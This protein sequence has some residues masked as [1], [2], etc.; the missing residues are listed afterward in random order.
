[1]IEE[2]LL[3]TLQVSKDN[4]RTPKFM[5]A[6]LSGIAEIL[7]ETQTLLTLEMVLSEK[8]LSFILVV[9]KKVSDL[10]CGQLASQ[11]P[12]LETEAVQDYVRIPENTS[13]AG[14][15]LPLTKTDILPIQTY[16]HFE[17]DTLSH[18]SG[19]F[20]GFAANEKAWIQLVLG[21]VNKKAIP[22]KIS[23]FFKSAIRHRIRSGDAD[24][25]SM[26]I[27]EEEN[28]AVKALFRSTIRLVCISPDPSRA[29]LELNA[30]VSTFKL[31]TKPNLNGFKEG[32]IRTDQEFLLYYK[33][34]LSGKK[35]FL[36]NS[37]E[38]ASIF[39]FPYKGAEIPQVIT[40]KAKRAEPP[41][42][43]PREGSVDE[44]D[45]SFFGETTFRNEKIRFGVKSVDRNR[46]FYTIGK[47]GMGKSKLLE[48]MILE[49]LNHGKGV[50][51]LDPH[52][53]LC[54][55]TLKYIPQ[56]RIYDTIYFN[57]AD[58]DYP[59]GFNPMEKVE[60][61]EYKQNVV[62]GF[63][64]IFKKLFGWNW[65][66][67]LEHVLRYTVL[68]LLDYPNSTVL[69]IPRMLSDNLFRQEVISQIHDP[70]VKKFWTTEFASWSDQFSQEA[71]VPIINKVG[72]FVA[73]PLI[74]N[75]VGQPQSV[76]NLSEIMNNG[77]I[78]LCNLSAGKLGEEN[79]ALLGSMFVTKIWQ[80]ALERAST[81]EQERKDFYLY[82]DE[83]Q[84][85][86]TSAFANI[87]SEARKYRLCLIF[88]HQY[89]GQLPEGISSTIF[90]NVGSIVS[91]RVG[92]EDAAILEK[93]FAPEFSAKDLMNLDMREIYVK[94]AIDG[95][96]ALPFSAKTITLPHVDEDYSQDVIDFSRRKWAKPRIEVEK[97]IM[98][99]ESKEFKGKSNKI[100]SGATEEEQKF[101]EPIV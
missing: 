90:G 100:A 88:A 34:R 79:A 84:N 46:H 85:F 54:E 8:F 9:P 4:E 61:F 52:G 77:K 81:P 7:R 1:M 95:Q 28:K 101:S 58:I 6:A 51:V 60:S 35:P 38:I 10:V 20:S 55:E 83:F 39:H 66:Q 64:G 32:K 2:F 43:L 11:Y 97:E 17:V 94:M 72:Q 33:Q 89:M 14:T 21:V 96:T 87:L 30:L 91:F 25:Q 27:Q 98:E 92:G 99:F 49:D 22:F 40:T 70:L 93:E 57:P 16:P 78:L 3:L 74:R 80:A 62:A 50:A 48:L 67:R 18:I 19:I 86:A 29:R 59:I 13:F 63:I 5:E 31:F 71:I 23:R 37:E 12:D 15:E 45:L 68:A 56:R 73:S 65:N 69:G 47:T 42:N 26:I 82:V 53:D 76:I 24:Y 36:L 41:A 44:K 75:I